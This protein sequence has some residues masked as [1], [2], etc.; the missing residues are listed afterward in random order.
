MIPDNTHTKYL[1]C[2]NSKRKRI[3]KEGIFEEIESNRKLKFGSVMELKKKTTNYSM[4]ALGKGMFQRK[5][6]EAHSLPSG[7]IT[8]LPT[9]V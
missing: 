6:S 9:Y 5:S 2:K 3:Q 1:P 4:R 7:D 8:W